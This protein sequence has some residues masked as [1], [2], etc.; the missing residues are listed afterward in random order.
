MNTGGGG[1]MMAMGGGGGGMMTTGGGGGTMNTGGG[2]GTMN[3]G[4]GGGGVMDTDGGAG[5]SGLPSACD[6]PTGSRVW[7]DDAGAVSAALPGLWV[8]CGHALTSDESEVGLQIGADLRFAILLAGPDGG[9][10]STSLLEVGQAAVNPLG[11]FNGH[12]SFN[13][14][15]TTDANVDYQTR[16]FFTNGMPLQLVTTNTNVFWLRYV[17]VDP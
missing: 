6:A 5:G 11:I 13:L 2:G 17:R 4:G 9:V 7:I 1:G 3:T 10:P 16:P 8:R 12:L 14:D 15:F